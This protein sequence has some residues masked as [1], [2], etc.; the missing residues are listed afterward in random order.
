MAAALLATGASALALLLGAAGLEILSLPHAV[1]LIA[2]GAVAFIGFFTIQLMAQHRYGTKQFNAMLK[3]YSP[4]WM[5]W[6]CNGLGLTAFILWFF[7]LAYRR[8]EPPTGG[9]SSLIAGT[10]CLFFSPAAF[11]TFYSYQALRPQLRRHC[12]RGHD[13]PVG[14]SYCPECGEH[15]RPER[16]ET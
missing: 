1:V 2:S 3:Q 7:L 8:Y 10:F 15:V 12:S 5:R 16:P 9:V 13:M 4:K 6:L 11:L 14:A